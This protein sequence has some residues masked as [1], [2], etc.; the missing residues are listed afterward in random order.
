MCLAVPGKLESVNDQSDLLRMGVVDFNG[1]KREVSLAFVPDA[2]VGDWLLV[3]VG[4]AI[5]IVDEEEAQQTLADYQT[6][7]QAEESFNG[8]Q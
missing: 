6:L 4:A 5:G 1:T 3:H 7:L 2:V 8:P